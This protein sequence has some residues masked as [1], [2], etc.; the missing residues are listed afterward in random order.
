MTALLHGAVNFRDVGGLPAEG[1]TTRAGVLWRSGNLA[2]LDDAAVAEIAALGLARIIDLRDD[3]EVQHAP[4]PL[5]RLGARVQREPLFL[6]SVASF[7]VEDVTLD[8][9]YRRMIEGAPER[10]AAAVRGIAAEQPALV[11]CTVG[12]DRTGVVVALA[13]SAA[14]VERDAVVADYART[15]GLLP[16]WRNRRVLAE[17]G[18]VHPGARNL[19]DLA[20][21]SPAPVMARLLARVDAGYGSPA[22]FLREHGMSAAELADLRSVLIDSEG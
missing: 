8:E 13:L 21:R 10:I 19:A 7:F 20:T 2:R 22:G 3:D 15:E 17:L 1:G 18:R 14:G 4:S 5:D 9:L 12:K 11:H 6:G 16:R